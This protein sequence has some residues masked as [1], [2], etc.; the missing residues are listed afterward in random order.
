MSF[1]VSWAA[2]WVHAK[3]T[4]CWSSDLCVGLLTSR[5]R[6][7]GEK[8][9]VFAKKIWARHSPPQQLSLLLIVSPRLVFKVAADWCFDSL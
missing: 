3:K 7:T 9:R 6:Y 2:A 5:A 1:K 8:I 4:E